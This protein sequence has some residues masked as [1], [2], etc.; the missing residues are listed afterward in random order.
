MKRFTAQ[1]DGLTLR[2]DLYEPQGRGR[3][4]QPLVL[5]SHGMNTSR[6]EWYDFP[7]RLAQAGYAV[8]AFDY[9][10]HGQSEGEMGVRSIDTTRRDLEAVLAEAANEPW[11]DAE[12][13]GLLGHSLGATLALHVAADLPVEC[14]VALAPP[15]R[16][17]AE[18][19]A[20]Q[21]VA[22]NVLRGINTGVTLLYKPGIR[23]PRTVNYA[24]LYADQSAVA[25]AERDDF[26]QTTLPVK[27]Y[28]SL[29]KDVDGEKAASRLTK[30]T[31]VMAAEWDVVVGKWNTRKVYDALAGP[32]KFVEVPKSGHSMCGDARAAFVAQH[33]VEFLDEH[34]RG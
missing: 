16:L 10:G 21:F 34:L 13:V 11:V 6:V 20:A 33:C 29:I 27:N 24:D 1:A 3:G 28:K 26:L 4:P 14:V 23:I 5:F 8:A 30:P 19:N 25:R 18:I 9:R 22:Y 31:L 7:Q 15:S 17:R 12:R 2:G 32:K